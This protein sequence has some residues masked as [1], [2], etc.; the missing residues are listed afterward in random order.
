MKKRFLSSDFVQD[1]YLKHQSLKQISLTVEEYITE[2]ERLTMMY[3]LEERTEH[4]IARFISGL[5]RSIAKKVDIQPYWTFEVVCK[6]AMK[7]EK[8]A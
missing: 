2:F 8:H 7:V 3:D 6:V 4:K 1:M 5:E